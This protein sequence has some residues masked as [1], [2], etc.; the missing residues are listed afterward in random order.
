MTCTHTGPTKPWGEPTDSTYMSTRS[1]LSLLQEAAAEQGET[2][3]T[4]VPVAERSDP[5]RHTPTCRIRPDNGGGCQPET[6]PTRTP[7]WTR[8]STV[9]G[10]AAPR[11]RSQSVTNAPTRARGHP[12]WP[13][14]SDPLN[15][16]PCRFITVLEGNRPMSATQAKHPSHGSHHQVA[17]HHHQMSEH[18]PAKK[19][20]T[21]AHEHSEQAHK[22][23]TTAR[24]QSHT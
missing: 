19:H 7:V 17:A 21:A 23:T 5:P 12:P 3:R 11:L 22:H 4:E 16:Q 24:D 15:R 10:A 13:R 20:A 1:W 6:I 18:E 14:G 8:S 9:G 2:G